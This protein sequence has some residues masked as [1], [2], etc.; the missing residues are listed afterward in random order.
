MTFASLAWTLDENGT[1]DDQN[2][3]TRRGY[4]ELAV[5]PTFPGMQES[6]VRTR[7]RRLGNYVNRVLSKDTT[8][9][10][11]IAYPDPLELLL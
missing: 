7:N 2:S 9:V 8:D 10:T 1:P 6:S 3:Y 5:A 11:G 4:L